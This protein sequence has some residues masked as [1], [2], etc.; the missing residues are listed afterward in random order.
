MDYK[1]D[2]IWLMQGDCLE[3]MKEIPDRSVELVVTSPPYAK[4][5]SYN[6]AESSEYLSFIKPIVEKAMEK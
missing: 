6:G 5:R 2:N 4:Q 3:R 1:D